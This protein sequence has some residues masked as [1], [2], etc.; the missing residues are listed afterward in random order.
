VGIRLITG[1]PPRMAS[2]RPAAVF[3]VDAIGLY[4]ANLNRGSISA[5]TPYRRRP[6]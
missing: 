4:R 2:Y 3:D 6:C 1:D 5:A